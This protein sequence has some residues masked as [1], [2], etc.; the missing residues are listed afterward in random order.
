MEVLIDLGIVIFI[1]LMIFRGYRRGG[2]LSLMSFLTIFVAFSGA[3]ILSVNFCEPVGR[4][5]QPVVKEIITDVLYDALKNEN[6][7][8]DA[9]ISTTKES[10]DGSTAEYLTLTRAFQILTASKDIDKLDGFV[11]T[12]KE[13]LL[14]GTVQM[15]GSA[16]EMISTVIGREIARVG[17]FLISFALIM[18]FWMLLTRAIKI[19]LKIPGFK[20][21]NAYAGAIIGFMMGI[22]LVFVFAWITK[23]TIISWESMSRTMLYEYFAKNTPMDMLAQAYEINLDL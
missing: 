5:V 9:T 12:A 1:P 17:I 22:L 10:E 20:E 21:A 15:S 18:A 2:I 4:L 7:I 19:I 3:T 11:Q 23:G 16:T 13:T 14:L 6:I 8:I